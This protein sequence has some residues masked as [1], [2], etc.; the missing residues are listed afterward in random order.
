MT[1]EEKQKTHFY[2]IGSC[3]EGEEFM[4][5]DINYNIKKQNLSN[6]ITIVPFIKNIEKAYNSIDV[7]LVPS[8]VDDSFPTTVLEGM[9]FS[10]RKSTRLNSSHEIPPRM[11]S[12]A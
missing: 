12:S 2:F 9:F 11:T 8:L 7:V 6:I 1:E 4:L 10:D 3:V 5:D